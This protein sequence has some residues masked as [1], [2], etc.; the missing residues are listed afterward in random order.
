MN[1]VCVCVCV[2]V[3]VV[4]CVCMCVCVCEC[5]CVVVVVCVCVCGCVCMCVCLFK[6][7]IFIQVNQDVT[8]VTVQKIDIKIKIQTGPTLAKEN[9]YVQIRLWY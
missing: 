7:D 8:N 6:T 3:C 1:G 5:V 4:V 9:F 2:C